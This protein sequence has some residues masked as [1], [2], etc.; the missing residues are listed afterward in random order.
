M[1]KVLWF[2]NSRCGSIDRS[3]A[4]NYIGGWLYALEKELKAN[5]DVDL[6]V[7][8]FSEHKENPFEFNG[9]SYYP[10]SLSVP[11]NPLLRVLDRGRAPARFDTQAIVEGMLS[12]VSRVKPDIIHIHGTEERFGL[13]ADKVGNIP[14]AYS[15]QGLIGPVV[16]K[17]FSGITREQMERYEPWSLRLRNDSY[18]NDYRSFQYRAE[19]EARFLRQA[20]YVFGRT[21][22]DRAITGLFNSQRHYYVVNEILRQPFYE[23]QW[24]KQGFGPK[25]KIVS[26]I[27]YGTYKGYETLLRAAQL[28]KQ[29][30][31]FGF[32]W[33]VAGY[34]EIDIWSKIGTKVTGICPQ[35]C[36]VRLLGLQ[37]ADTLSVLLASSDIYCHVSHIENSPNSVCEAMLVGMPV[38][39]SYAGGTA[40]LLEHKKEG[41]LVQDGD[42]YVLAGSIVELHDDFERAK[43]YGQAARLHALDRHNPQNVSK[44]LLAAY[45]DIISLTKPE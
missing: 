41:L 6:H 33:C 22:W 18:K 29:Y 2:T 9:V 5:P 30:A 1:M 39:A 16:N 45:H 34:E 11:N 28:L 20:K 44:E 36:G 42:P 14:V 40:S 13:I 31:S 15:I 25:L 4:K 37:D 10:V 17:Y 26:T 21:F 12:V 38:I 19:R 23:R 32:E 7:C 24:S 35:D 8:F 3:G 27:S 43:G